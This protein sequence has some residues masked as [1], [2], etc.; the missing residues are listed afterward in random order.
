MI[1]EI[2]KTKK[3]IMISRINRFKKY[4]IIGK[5][6]LKKLRKLL[7][8]NCNNFKFSREFSC[9]YGNISGDNFDLN[10]TFCL[11]YDMIHIGSGTSFSFQNMILT[12][13]HQNENF[14]KI[15]TKPVIIGKNCWITSRVIILPGVTIGDN[16]IVAAG[17]VVSKNIPS[18]V[19]V[20]GNPARI[21]KYIYREKVEK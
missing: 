3:S 4:P 15:I 14:N 17:S 20:G 7:S 18:N 19:M 13:T 2:P 1:D 12:S 6:F 9:K 5:F 11:D 8:Q 16:V 10:D 21:I